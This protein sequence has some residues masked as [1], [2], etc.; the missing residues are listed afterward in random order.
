MGDASNPGAVSYINV[1]SVAG[2]MSPVSINGVLPAAVN[3]TAGN[4]GFYSHE[5]MYTKGAGSTLAQSFL[6]YIAGPFQSKIPAG[7]ATLSTTSAL[8]LSDK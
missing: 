4:Y 6:Q 8:S 1:A 2:G 5:H 7:F 3:V